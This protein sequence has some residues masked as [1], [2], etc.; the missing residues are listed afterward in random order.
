ML[1]FRYNCGIFFP[2]S[3]YMGVCMVGEIIQRDLNVRSF[4]NRPVVCP[5]CPSQLHFPYRNIRV[6]GRI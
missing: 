1:R 4:I 5:I 2:N 3:Q 6:D